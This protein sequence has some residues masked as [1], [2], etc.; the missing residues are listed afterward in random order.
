MN[1]KY[2]SL[3]YKLFISL[4]IMS[5]VAA[6][7]AAEESRYR[8]EIL[9]LSHLA[10][11]EKGQ[12]VSWPSDYSFAIDFLTPLEPESDTEE[13]GSDEAKPLEEPLAVADPMSAIDPI[14]AED[15]LDP[16]AA[17]EEVD[18]GPVHV[19]EMSEP[20]QEAWRRLRLSGPFRPLQFLAW[21]QS[22][23]APFP[24]LRVHD[25]D[26]VLIDDPYFELRAEQ[27]EQAAL[28]A[29]AAGQAAAGSGLAQA[30]ESI[31]EPGDEQ[32]DGLEGEEELPPPIAYYRLDGAVTLR[33]SRFLHLDLDLELRDPLYDEIAPYPAAESA[34]PSLEGEAVAKPSAFRVYRLEQSRQVKTGKMNYFDGPV[35]GVL[36]YLTPVE[37]DSIEAGI[38]NEGSPSPP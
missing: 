28:E 32:R 24:T 33:R 25:M 10:H 35:L 37:A 12:E 4:L 19:E 27:A 22:A 18:T 13:D 34:A 8:V 21:E 31:V 20:M 17:P 30:K 26:V 3:A 7:L 36:A 5:M 1:N 29:E 2:I 16:D 38:P 11:E 6:P 23:D 9:V 14:P 15:P